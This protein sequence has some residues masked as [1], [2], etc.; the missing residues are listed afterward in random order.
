M[1]MRNG[2]SSIKPELLAPA[3]TLASALAALNSGADAVYAG[4]GRFNAREMGENFDYDDMSRLSARV[5]KMR[6]R[7]YNTLNTLVK[8]DE[9]Y[10]DWLNAIHAGHPIPCHHESS[11]WL[12]VVFGEGNGVCRPKADR[13]S[14]LIPNRQRWLLCI[15]DPHK[16]YYRTISKNNN[17]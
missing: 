6:R 3:G 15:V 12:W 2:L 11:R 9:P 17:R 7:L 16:I 1:P 4:L 8:Q 14:L 10:T 5:K 13:F